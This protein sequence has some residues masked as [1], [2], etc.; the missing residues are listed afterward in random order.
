MKKNENLLILR[1]AEGIGNQLF[2]YANAF[3]LSKK[4]NYKLLIDNTSGYF[5]KKNQI[6]S[7]ELNKFITN[8]NIASDKFKFDTYLKDI[9]RKFLKKLTLFLLKKIFISKKN[10]LKKHFFKK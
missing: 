10:S 3:S 7:Y 5:K 6:R 8:L 1:V 4:Y 9:K 2:M